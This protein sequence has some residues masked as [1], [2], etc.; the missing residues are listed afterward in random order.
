ME[1]KNM[2][3]L[4]IFPEGTTSNNRYLL[5]F[6]KGAFEPNVPIKMRLFKCKFKNHA[7]NMLNI[8]YL[9]CFTQYF[10]FFLK[11]MIL[12]ILHLHLIV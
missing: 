12:G 1:G 11:M 2:S 5:S 4:C 10:N 9:A 8:L 7:E 3:P 6:K